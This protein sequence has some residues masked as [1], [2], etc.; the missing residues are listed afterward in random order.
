MGG[1]FW[2]FAG[3]ICLI[4]PILFRAVKGPTAPDRVVAINAVSTNITLAILLWAF[5]QREPM[6]IDVALV[7]VICGFVGVV[8]TLQVLTTVN[9]DTLTAKQTKRGQN[10]GGDAA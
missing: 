7:F 4:F 1:A 9:A 3:T 2:L 10:D 6:F 5:L 8:C